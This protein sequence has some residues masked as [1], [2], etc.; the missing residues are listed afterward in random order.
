MDNNNHTYL[1]VRSVYSPDYENFKITF[2]NIINTF[3]L[4]ISQMS[5]ISSSI[6]SSK[7]HHNIQLLLIG[8]IPKKKWQLLLIQLINNYIDKINIHIEFFSINKGKYVM[9]NY[10]GEL[11]TNH[12]NISFASY[13]GIL[14]CDHD[15]IFDKMYE[16]LFTKLHTLSK[17]KIND[18]PIGLIA[19]NQMSDIRHQVNIYDN[20]IVLNGAKL[21]YPDILTNGAIALGCFYCDANIF[22]MILPL[23]IISV[24]G[25]DDLIIINK[26][27]ANN[28]N[29]VVCL[30]YT[31]DH[32]MSINKK[33]I[34]WKYNM[35]LNII[36]K[37]ISYNE[38]MQQSINFWNGF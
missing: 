24:Y 36:K 37:K 34:E 21:V 33:Y 2:K 1:F 19:L 10:I 13:D 29:P 8:Y 5:S 15:I 12:Q 32:P 26:I 18:K 38:S 6:S 27:V 30:D 7:S 31:V 9:F 14:Y 23:E 11:L 16:E 20:K 35:V 17:E 25:L 3:Q 28:Y 22:S 4:I